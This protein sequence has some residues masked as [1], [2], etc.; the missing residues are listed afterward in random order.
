NKGLLAWS[1]GFKFSNKVFK[2]DAPFAAV[3][4]IQLLCLFLKVTKMSP[5]LLGFVGETIDVLTRWCK[6]MGTQFL[7]LLQDFRYEVNG[8][9]YIFHWMPVLGKADNSAAAKATG[10]HLE[11][12]LC[13]RWIA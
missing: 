7:Q 8:M 10:S 4:C 12:F 9:Q 6:Y 3:S 11:I 2:E 5:W 1:L 13:R